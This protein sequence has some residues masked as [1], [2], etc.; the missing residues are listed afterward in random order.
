M[1]IGKRVVHGFPVFK[2]QDAVRHLANQVAVVGYKENGPRVGL[3][4][5]LQGLL[6]RNVHMV[7]G[8]VQNQEI[9]TADQKLR[10]H[11]AGLFPSRQGGNFLRPIGS[12]KQIHTQGFSGLLLRHGREKAGKML[13][14]RLVRLEPGRILVKVPDGDIGAQGKFSSQ[15]AD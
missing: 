12:G 9:R 4:S 5:R 7:G 3:K 10:Q 13:Q 8:L 1:L 15:R 14:H 11:Q 6:S 2:N